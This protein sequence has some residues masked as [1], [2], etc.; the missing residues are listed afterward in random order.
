MGTRGRL[1]S[2]L[3]SAQRGSGG[4]FKG[5]GGNHSPGAAGGPSPAVR[6]SNLPP[7]E[8]GCLAELKEKGKA[9]LF[10]RPRITSR[11]TYRALANH[12]IAITLLSD[13]ARRGWSGECLRLR[14]LCHCVAFCAC[15]M[16]MLF[17][18]T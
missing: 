1:C 17:G 12:R 7:V 4:G 16:L 10:P 9:C 18:L 3:L 15:V 2:T 11:C 14:W 6:P 8:G 13:I 5:S